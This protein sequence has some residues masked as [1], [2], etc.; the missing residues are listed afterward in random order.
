MEN[1]HYA[2]TAGNG[3]REDPF[4]MPP[5]GPVFG[6]KIEREVVETLCGAKY[7]DILISRMYLVESLLATVVRDGDSER[8]IYFDLKEASEATRK[9]QQEM[10]EMFSAPE[11]VV[12]KEK[13][14]QQVV[15]VLSENRRAKGRKNLIVTILVIAGIIAAVILLFDAF[16]MLRP[17]SELK[18]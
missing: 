2:I 14:M 9:M 3:T 17:P 16:V 8:K 7:D 12:L 6:A 11:G 15:D 18:W 1:I 4:L 5:V 13:L 10:S